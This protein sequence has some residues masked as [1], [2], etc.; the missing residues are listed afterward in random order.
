MDTD[1]SLLR[2][3]LTPALRGVSHLWSMKLITKLA[4]AGI[5]CTLFFCG[6]AASA[7][8]QE[9]C[10]CIESEFSSGVSPGLC[11]VA[12]CITDCDGNRFFLN[13]INKSFDT[14]VKASQKID[15]SGSGLN[16]DK[17]FKE[18]KLHLTLVREWGL[19]YFYCR[20]D[21]FT[22]DVTDVVT[23]NENKPYTVRLKVDHSYQV[24]KADAVTFYDSNKNELKHFCSTHNEGEYGSWDY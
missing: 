23:K 24:G 21:D 3:L 22:L 12:V 1:R 18:V 10:L 20:V 13:D 2:H 19:L 9:E 5:L 7:S 16:C 14:G 15:L 6:P 17:P 11:L 8:S 4:I